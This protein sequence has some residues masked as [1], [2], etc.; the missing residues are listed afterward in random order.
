MSLNAETKRPDSRLFSIPFVLGLARLVSEHNHGHLLVA[1]VMQPCQLAAHLK[2]EDAARRLYD[3][4]TAVLP[5]GAG[6]GLPASHGCCPCEHGR[7]CCAK[8]L[9]ILTS[10]ADT[11]CFTAQSIPCTSLHRMVGHMLMW[12][13]RRSSHPSKVPQQTLL[14]CICE[15]YYFMLYGRWHICL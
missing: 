5:L 13:L 10:D 8:L 2:A 12:Y 14:L 9:A 15:A 7:C 6:F 11:C 3:H 4:G 1:E